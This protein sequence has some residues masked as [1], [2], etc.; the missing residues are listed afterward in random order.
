LEIKAH[1][2][3]QYL[4]NKT[5]MARPRKGRNPDGTYRTT[6][7]TRARAFSQAQI[8]RGDVQR[9]PCEVCGAEPAECHHIDYADPGR[10]MWLCKA[11]HSQTHSQFGK[12]AP[13]DWM[14]DIRLA[15]R[16]IDAYRRARADAGPAPSRGSSEL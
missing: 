13:V 9:R 15:Q 5:Q 12:P 7:K 4:Q 2:I 1:N 16:K 3:I 11:H 8:T 6:Q 14:A 10:V